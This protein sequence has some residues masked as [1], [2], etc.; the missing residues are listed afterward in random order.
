MNPDTP[1]RAGALDAF[2]V[3]SLVN[4]KRVPRSAPKTI[5]A[6][7]AADAAPPPA[8]PSPAPTAAAPTAAPAAA[9]EASTGQRFIGA[10]TLRAYDE[11]ARV[12]GELVPMLGLGEDTSIAA[13]PASIS[14]LLADC[15]L[16]ERCWRETEDAFD[17]L[18]DQFDE[19]AKVIEDATGVRPEPGGDLTAIAQLLRTPSVPAEHQQFATALA[20]APGQPIHIHVHVGGAA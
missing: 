7:P 20:A 16:F 4:G 11:A 6:Q 2:A 3:P 15:K 5:E 13:L 12:L 14:K 1:T 8:P 19:L 9:P 10:D 17:K 18:V